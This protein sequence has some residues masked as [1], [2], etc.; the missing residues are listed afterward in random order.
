[1]TGA[2]RADN[3]FTV[4]HAGGLDQF[5]RAGRER[6]SPTVRPPA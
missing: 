3:S 4:V 2:N 1:V 5:G 6:R